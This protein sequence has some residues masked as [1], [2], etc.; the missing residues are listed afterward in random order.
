MQ[1]YV[2]SDAR[3]GRIA[4]KLWREGAQNIFA[5]HAPLETADDVQFIPALDSFAAKR[6]EAPDARF[7]VVEPPRHV[8]RVASFL[9]AEPDEAAPDWRTALGLEAEAALPRLPPLASFTLRSRPRLIDS[10]RAGEH[11][12]RKQRIA[13]FLSPLL[14]FQP[15]KQLQRYIG[16][17]DFFKWELSEYLDQESAG[18]NIHFL[19][20]NDYPDSAFDTQ[21]ISLRM[22]RHDAALQHGY[23]RFDELAS[24]LANST[25]LITDDRNLACMAHGI[26]VAVAFLADRYAADDPDAALFGPGHIEPYSFSAETLRR[27]FR[28][29]EQFGAAKEL[30]AAAGAEAARLLTGADRVLVS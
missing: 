19:Y 20:C 11:G 18:A 1:I 22:R 24:L 2:Y 30:L 3:P 5:A 14:N 12:G 16:Y 13:V 10:M 25:R 6:Q 21:D 29:L 8:R 15:A 26:G 27:R 4:A 9:P 28:A 7:V 23:S 17:H